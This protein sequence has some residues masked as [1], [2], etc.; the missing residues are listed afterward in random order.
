MKKRLAK[1]TIKDVAEHAGVSTTTISRFLN[2]RF[3][4]MSRETKMRI[5]QSVEQLD[6]KPNQMARGLRNERSNTIGFVVADIGNPYTVSVIQGVEEVCTQLGYSIII[7]N[8]N[9]NPEKER[10]CLT[11][12]ETKQIDG[13]IINS[14]GKNNDLLMRI[15]KSV[16]V[17]LI[18]RK[19]PG[20]PFDT[21]TTNNTQGIMLAIEHL[22][23]RGCQG[24]HLMIATPDGIS[25]RYERIFAF[26]QFAKQNRPPKTS[27]TIVESYSQERITAHVKELVENRSSQEMTGLI[28]GNGKLSL[29]ALKAVHQLHCQV[30]KDL[31]LVGFDDPEWASI[32]RPTLTVIA[33][34]TYEIG[35]QAA[36][37]IIARIQKEQEYLPRTVELMMQL[38]PRESTGRQDI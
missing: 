37:M 33:Q 9:E 8:A 3:E 19:L 15:G 32:A 4:A 17:L 13:L 2:G 11:M 1:I 27:L 38:I 10:D 18:D 5:Q 20:M 26:E 6:Y 35:R 30:P 7:S 36:E 24:I 34:P 14:T 12:L 31:L 16:P 25:P 29:M 21:V 23:E 28:L 22:L